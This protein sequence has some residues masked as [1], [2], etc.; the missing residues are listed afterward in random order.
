MAKSH[1]KTKYPSS[2]PWSNKILKLLKHG[3]ATACLEGYKFHPEMPQS[4]IFFSSVGTLVAYLQ[5]HLMGKSNFNVPKIQA[6]TIE[7]TEEPSSWLPVLG[8]LA[9]ESIHSTFV[10]GTFVNP[11]SP[12]HLSAVGRHCTLTLTQQ[13]WANLLRC[14]FWCKVADGSMKLQKLL[15]TNQKELLDSSANSW[16]S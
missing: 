3:R 9:Q 14:R 16:N 11:S 2:N 15:P 6:R 10:T 4:S 13:F 8:V 5:S 1:R 12:W 7:A